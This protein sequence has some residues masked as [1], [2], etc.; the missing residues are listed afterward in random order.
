MVGVG[1]SEVCGLLSVVKTLCVP[2]GSDYITSQETAQEAPCMGIGTVACSYQ[3]VV[4]HFQRT[5]PDAEGEPGGRVSH[6]NGDEAERGP[7]RV[8]DG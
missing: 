7:I 2:L 1:L 3:T 5:S 8:Q 6:G 4:L